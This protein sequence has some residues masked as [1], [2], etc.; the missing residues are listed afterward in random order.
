MHHVLI[1]GKTWWMLML[2]GSWIDRR[3][4]YWLACVEVALYCPTRPL[5]L[6]V[7]TKVPLVL[8]YRICIY[9]T[10]LIYYC[11]P[12]ETQSR[13]LKKLACSTV[14][15]LVYR[16][17]SSEVITVRIGFYCC[18]VVTWWLT[19]STVRG[20][21][22]WSHIVVHSGGTT[23]MSYSVLYSIIKIEW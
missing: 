22:W 17:N 6:T 23:C 5:Q 10:Y 15:V 3:Q 1:L 2:I 11:T 9:C 21:L 7:S 14:T 18:I 8:L 19:V 12:E 4:W 16:R 13:N 20:R